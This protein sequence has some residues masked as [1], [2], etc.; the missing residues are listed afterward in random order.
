MG[1][2]FF[3]SDCEL[4]LIFIITKVFLW[5]YFRIVN[6]QGASSGIKLLL[7]FVGG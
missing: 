3:H 7:G 4:A 5:T 1:D 6:K 2:L